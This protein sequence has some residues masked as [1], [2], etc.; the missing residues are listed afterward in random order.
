MSFISRRS[1]FAGTFGHGG[2]APLTNEQI[3]QAA[4][5]AFAVDKHESR[6]ERYAYIPTSVSGGENPRVNGACY[7]GSDG[8]V[9][10]VP[11]RLCAG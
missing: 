10:Q 7:A 1:S 9:G 11:Q 3:R 6:S 4:P 8:L 5:S 2:T